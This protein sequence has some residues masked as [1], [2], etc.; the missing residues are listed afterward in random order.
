[1]IDLWGW[2]KTC[3]CYPSGQRASILLQ[4]ML[5]HRKLRDIEALRPLVS[6]QA[7]ASMC[8]LSAFVPSA[9]G[10]GLRRLVPG[11]L[12]LA[13]AALPPFAAHLGRVRRRDRE[14][15]AGHHVAH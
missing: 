2:G 9:G 4:Q 12:R 5:Q 11:L 13:P 8:V 14:R 10:G 6:G 15:K 7:E 1:M 3:A